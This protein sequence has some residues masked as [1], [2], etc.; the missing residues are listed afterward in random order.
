MEDGFLDHW[1]LG[2][3]PIAKIELESR[4]PEPLQ[5]TFI[6]GSSGPWHV[7]RI[8]AVRGQGLS[9]AARLTALEGRPGV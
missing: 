8:T 2:G 1:N 7:D 4:M 6:G 3:P 9:E 5:V